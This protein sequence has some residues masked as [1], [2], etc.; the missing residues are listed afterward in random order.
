MINYINYKINKSSNPVVI[1]CVA[2]VGRSSA[3]AAIASA[4][5]MM[6]ES[7]NYEITPLALLALGA[8]YRYMFGSS[9]G[10]FVTIHTYLQQF[11]NLS[12]FSSLFNFNSANF[13]AFA[14]NDQLVGDL[15]EYL[16][17]IQNRNMDDNLTDIEKSIKKSKTR[18]NAS[19]PKEFAS[20]SAIPNKKQDQ[21][22]INASISV[23]DTSERDC[24][25][26]QTPMQNTVNDFWHMV[27]RT[28]SSNAIMMLEGNDFDHPVFIE[29]L[30]TDY[31]KL[32]SITKEFINNKITVYKVNVHRKMGKY[33]IFHFI[34][35]CI[36]DNFKYLITMINRYQI[37]W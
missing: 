32:T 4:Q 5:N 30:S 3:V 18:D 20:I 19:I 10:P 21:V 27:A 29:G 34:L 2:G 9:S 24:I 25:I 8:K 33:V 6:N 7:R 16:K 11:I 13:R 15:F 26:T 31:I 1:H 12:Q 28:C 17:E 14:N 37:M 36:I 35:I 23:C 22:Y